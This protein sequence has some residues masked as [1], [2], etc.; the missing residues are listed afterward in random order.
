MNDHEWMNEW[1]QIKFYESANAYEI[2]WGANEEEISYLAYHAVYNISIHTQD[3][4]REARIKET[5]PYT[6]RVSD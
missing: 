1:T 2:V 3:M 5:E 4:K 6:F